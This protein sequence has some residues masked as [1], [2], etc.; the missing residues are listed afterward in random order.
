[1]ARYIDI[2]RAGR[3]LRLSDEN[4]SDGRN[5]DENQDD[6][7]DERPRDLELR[8]AVRLRGSRLILSAAI[9]EYDVNE[10]RFDENEYDRAQEQQAVPEKIYFTSEIGMRDERGIGMG[11]VARDSRDDERR[12]QRVGCNPPEAVRTFHAK[13]ILFSSCRERF[14]FAA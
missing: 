12:D 2:E 9:L 4:R 3:S 10:S 5:R 6:R 7:G 14:T 8:A 13:E 1:M 11:F